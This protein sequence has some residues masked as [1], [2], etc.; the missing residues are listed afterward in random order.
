MSRWICIFSA[1][2]SLGW[3]SPAS[4]IDVVVY[5][6]PPLSTAYM[7]PD[8]STRDAIHAAQQAACELSTLFNVPLPIPFAVREW[9]QQDDASY[10]PGEP[11]VTGQV[12]VCDTLAEQSKRFL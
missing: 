8:E 4:A 12:S 5:L 11:L 9:S 6:D 7:M 10:I 3:W 1:A 2:C